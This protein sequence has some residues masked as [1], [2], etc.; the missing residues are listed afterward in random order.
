MLGKSRMVCSE[1]YQSTD[2]HLRFQDLPELQAKQLQRGIPVP[3]VSME[4]QAGHAG[5]PQQ[6]YGMGQHQQQQPMYGQQA[7]NVHGYQ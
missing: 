4:P 6:H 3:G 1:F 7:T 5:Q 2:N